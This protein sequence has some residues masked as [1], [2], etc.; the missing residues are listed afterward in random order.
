M[1]EYKHFKEKEIIGLATYFVINLN[2]ARE[3]AN[4]PFIITSSKRTEEEN[5]KVG[6][7]KNSK[8]LTGEAVDLRILNGTQT[9]RMIE[10]LLSIPLFEVIIEDDHI[11]VEWNPTN[12][13]SKLFIR[14]A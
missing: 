12:L 11:H 10:A 3:R 9:A 4:V 5:K 2:F 7:I 14:N 6:G 13:I 8:H 1:R